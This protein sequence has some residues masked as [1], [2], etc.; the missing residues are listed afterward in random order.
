MSKMDASKKK[1]LLE[2]MCNMAQ[3]ITAFL[4]EGDYL[5]KIK[6]IVEEEVPRSFRPGTGERMLFGHILDLIE[7]APTDL[8]SRL[9]YQLA[10]ARILIREYYPRYGEYVQVNDLDFEAHHLELVRK[11]QDRLRRN[12]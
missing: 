9:S 7:D 12:A 5:P 10:A 1:M 8:T 6:I 11:A 4:T 2:E 3:I